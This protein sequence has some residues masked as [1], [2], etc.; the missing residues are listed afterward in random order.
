MCSPYRFIQILKYV[1]PHPNFIN[2]VLGNVVR[3]MR[4]PWG[5]VVGISFFSWAK[6]E[7]P[8]LLLYE[9]IWLSLSNS[10]CPDISSTLLICA[11][12]QPCVCNCTYGSGLV[13]K[14]LDCQ[15][16]QAGMQQCCIQP[17]IMRALVDKIN[18]SKASAF[19]SI[20]YYARSN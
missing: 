16:N 15:C 19:I 8:F 12:G 6:E 7:I 11:E 14:D 17:V 9:H 1:G 2:S 10:R 20:F 13:L 3:N 5:H 4:S 18:K